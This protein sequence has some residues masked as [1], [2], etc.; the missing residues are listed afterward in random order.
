MFMMLRNLLNKI[1]WKK[2]EQKYILSVILQEKVKKWLKIDV[3]CGN[4]DYKNVSPRKTY[5]QND[6]VSV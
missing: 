6:N 5:E 3:F 2:T 1:V 4:R